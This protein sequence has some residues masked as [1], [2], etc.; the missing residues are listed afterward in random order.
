MKNVRD[1]FVTN[2]NET[3]FAG[4]IWKLI[5]RSDQLWYDTDKK[6]KEI[7]IRGDELPPDHLTAMFWG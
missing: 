3:L 1:I 5:L 4:E 6:E 2:E 7:W